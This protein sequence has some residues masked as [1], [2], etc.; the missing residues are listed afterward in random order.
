VPLG[1]W[2]RHELREP[3]LDT[4]NERTIRADGLFR[5]EPVKRLIDDHL[6]GR[7]DN[8]KALFTLFMFQRWRSRWLAKPPEAAPVT[9]A[10][11]S[12]EP[13]PAVA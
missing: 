1:S 11:T 5:P 6:S 3:L 2:F 10:E 4:L 13:V 12:G 9:A 7:C 8:R